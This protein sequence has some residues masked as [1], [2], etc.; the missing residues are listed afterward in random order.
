[1]T[2]DE[3]YQLLLVSARHQALKGETA[4]ADAYALGADA[5][6]TKTG[7]KPFKAGNNYVCGSCRQGVVGH[8]FKGR[9]LINNYCPYCGAKVKTDEILRY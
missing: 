6:H 4:L 5:L 2:N 7:I 1:M 8:S 3:A 9:P